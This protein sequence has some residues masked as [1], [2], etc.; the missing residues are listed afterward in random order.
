MYRACT[1]HRGNASDAKVE[2]SLDV[3]IV[4]AVSPKS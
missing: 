4:S 2:R 3:K 1:T